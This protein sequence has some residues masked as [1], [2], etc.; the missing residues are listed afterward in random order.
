MTSGRRPRATLAQKIE[1]LDF[2]HKSDKP[3]LETV[4]HFKA[5]VSISTSSFSDWLKHEDELRQR[6]NEAGPQQLKSSRRKPHYKYEEINRAMDLMVQQRLERQQPVSEPILREYWSIYAHQYGVDDPKRLVGF[7]HGW[8]SQFKKRHGLNRKREP[9]SATTSPRRTFIASGADDTATASP[10]DAE[11]RDSVF[12]DD[13]RSAINDS[14]LSP[15]LT[16]EPIAANSTMINGDTSTRE[17][18]GGQPYEMMAQPYHHTIEFDNFGYGRQAAAEGA[19]RGRTRG[20]TGQPG[21]PG[22]PG[23][24]GQLAHQLHNSPIQPLPAQM[25]PHVHLRPQTGHSSHSH[26]A[27]PSQNHRS[28]S[29]HQNIQAHQNHQS[30]PP[31]PIP[32]QPQPL[33]SS[34]LLQP[35]NLIAQVPVMEP[36]THSVNYKDTVEYL[37]SQSRDNGGTPGGTRSPSKQMIESDEPAATNAADIEKFIYRYAAAFFHQHQYEYPQTAKIFH[38]FKDSFFN[39]RIVN[40]RSMQQQL[41]RT[42]QEEDESQVADQTTRSRGRPVRKRRVASQLSAQASP[43][44]ASASTTGN[45]G[46]PGQASSNNT[47]DIMED[48]FLPNDVE[49]EGAQPQAATPRKRWKRT[50]A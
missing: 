20:H 35:R 38:Q 37:R 12:L 23:Q 26:S 32:T 22:L 24:P 4:D 33:S 47:S 44:P 21:L 48:F 1:A 13:P 14:I 42:E 6:F 34:H 5:A 40:L 30:H 9:G 28:H 16:N 43:G 25:A 19:R 3:Q 2:F 36:Q 11:T 15:A 29:N 46:V 39:E 31:P 8:L 18:S 17:Y 49:A 10:T 41:M 27:H 45:G 50:A 7:S